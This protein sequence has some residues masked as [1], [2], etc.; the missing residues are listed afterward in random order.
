M[1]IGKAG[2]GKSTVCQMLAKAMTSI[3]SENKTNTVEDDRYRLVRTQTTNP[4][5]ISIQGLYGYVNSLTNEWNDG[6][7]GKI[8]KDCSIENQLEYDWL[9]FDGYFFYV[10]LWMR[11]GWRI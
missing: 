8:A 10:V 4:K 11:C 5:S 2:S 1:I 3:A 9:I 7:I 6:I